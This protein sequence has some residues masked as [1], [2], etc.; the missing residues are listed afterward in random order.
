MRWLAGAL[1]L[2]LGCDPPSDGAEAQTQTD[3][4][5]SV[6]STTSDPTTT[7]TGSGAGGDFDQ[8]L[9]CQTWLAC[10]DPATAAQLDAQY[11]P[12]GSCWT[13]TASVVE[14]CD[15][16]CVQ[17][18]H[19]VCGGD[20][21][22][23]DT[24]DPT[25][26]DACALEVLAPGAVSWVEAGD[27]AARIPTEIGAVLERACSCHVADLDAFIGEAPLYY[28]NA[29]FFTYAQM[30]AVFEGAPMYVEVG[31][32]A[33]EELNM[34]PTYFCGEGEYGS[35]RADAY[36]ILQ[37]WIAADA[38]DGAQWLRVRPDDLPPLDE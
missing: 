2:L 11:G 36:A 32:R 6:G 23:D 27:D 26:T 8:T 16:D 5:T 29:R 37:A 28:G 33:L 10:L 25:A 18:Y 38:P 31:V 1:V 9:A 20:A 13:Q 22:D 15:A 7:T 21:S 4:S 12:G 17:G 14:M 24:G 34:P 35:L 3:G 30:Q 19:A